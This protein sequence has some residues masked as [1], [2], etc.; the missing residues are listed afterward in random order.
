M[1]PGRKFV[2][3]LRQNFLAR[4]ALSEQQNRNVYVGDQGRLGTDLAHGRAGGHEKDIIAE[5][6]DLARID[7]ALL[8]QALIDY[9]IELGFLKRL[10]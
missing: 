9:R 4:A 5:F 1:R 8:S 3:Q 7:R 10:G 2:D 6:F